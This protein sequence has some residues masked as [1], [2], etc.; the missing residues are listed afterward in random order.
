MTS[1]KL[2]ICPG[3]PCTDVRMEGNGSVAICSFRTPLEATNGLALDGL[4]V[5]NKVIS[6]LKEIDEFSIFFIF[7]TF[8]S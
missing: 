1:F 5:F 2:N 3:N 8:F 6:S 7:F 4:T